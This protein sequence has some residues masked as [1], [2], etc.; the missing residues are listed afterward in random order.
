MAG[1][2]EL[3]IKHKIVS[4]VA[5]FSPW[6]EIIERSLGKGPDLEIDGVEKIQKMEQGRNLVG[7]MSTLHFKS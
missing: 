1:K 3:A 4:L 2:K 5:V 7:C 6:T